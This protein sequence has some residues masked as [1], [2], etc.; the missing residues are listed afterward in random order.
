VTSLSARL[1]FWYAIAAT[2]TFAVLSIAG[3]FMLHNQMLH[4]LDQLNETQFK[5][6]HTALGPNYKTLTPQVIN[7][8]IRDTTE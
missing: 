1:A 7:E 8:R 6:L 4:Q 5:Q 3:Y 2:A